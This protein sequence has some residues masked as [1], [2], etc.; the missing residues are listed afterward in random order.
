MDGSGWLVGG[1][2]RSGGPARGAVFA[3]C[4]WFGCV[5]AVP[6]AD[7]RPAVATGGEL[8]PAAHP[9]GRRFEQPLVDDSCREFKERP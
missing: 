6:I 3:V 9:R 5:I 4:G 1:A 2:D 7:P 8:R